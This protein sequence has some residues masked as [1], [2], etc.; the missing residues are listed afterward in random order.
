MSRPDRTDGYLI[1]KGALSL[2]LGYVFPTTRRW[3]A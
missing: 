2:F 3:V 1:L